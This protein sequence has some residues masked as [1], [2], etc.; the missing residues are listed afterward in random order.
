MILAQAEYAEG[1]RPTSKKLGHGAETGIFVIYIAGNEQ[2]AAGLAL[3]WRPAACTH[4]EHAPA[5]HRTFMSE[6][7][8]LDGTA[9]VPLLTE[10][11]EYSQP[12][13]FCTHSVDASCDGL[14]AVPT[15]L[16]VQ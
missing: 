13:G 15:Y 7:A 3:I 8:L 14:Q 1:T 11:R 5:D 10:V 2:K 12:F 6:V 4:S 16:T 9:S